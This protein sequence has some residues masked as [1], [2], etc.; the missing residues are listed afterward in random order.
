MGRAFVRLCV[1]A[2]LW[3]SGASGQVAK[4]SADSLFD[5]AV[6]GTKAGDFVAAELWF[7][8]LRSEYPQDPRWEGGLYTVYFALKRDEDV[9]KLGRQNLLKDP[10]KMMTHQA[11]GLALTHLNRGDE[12][13]AELRRALPLAPSDAVR[14]SI[15]VQ[16]GDAQA[17]IG[18]RQE[19]LASFQEGKKLTGF[20]PIQLPLMMQALGDIEGAISEYQVLLQ[21][22]PNQ[23]I[24][25]N[26]L[27]YAF[28]ERGERLDY[29]LALARRL[30]SI[31]PMASTFADTLGWVLF[32]SG[33][34]EEAEETM[35]EA[36]R[37][38]GGMQGTLLDHLAAVMDA[39]AVWTEDRRALRGL[40]DGELKAG[41]V[42]KMRALMGKVRAK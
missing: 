42:A 41:D 25:L 34:I 38:E 37:L 27:A 31:V 40:L 16:I 11:V 9:V 28:A 30:V 29:A 33:Q 22:N 10:N 1:V 21:R 18:S 6:A 7:Q 17:K 36:V 8:Q 26:N 5:E 12:A 15:H 20:V 19:A 35:L 32:K 2:A 13:V 3:I 39:R 24:A 23:T 14:G 4:S